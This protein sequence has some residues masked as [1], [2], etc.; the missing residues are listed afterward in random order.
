MQAFSSL[1]ARFFLGGGH[2]LPL[3]PLSIRLEVESD[4]LH[5]EFATREAFWNKFQPGADEHYLLHLMRSDLAFIPELSYIAVEGEQIVGSIAF[6]KSKIVQHNGEDRKELPVITFG[7][8]SVVTTHQSKGIGRK[9]IS[10][11]LRTAK[12]QGHKAVVIYGDPRYYGRLGFRC[13]E[14]YDITN[15]AGEFAISLLV[16]ALTDSPNPLE[17]FGGGCFE[18]ASIFQNFTGEGLE[19]YD[20]A[21]PARENLDMPY[22]TDFAVMRSL[23]YKATTPVL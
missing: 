12:E 19:E 14:R 17:A 5:T 11:G 2:V 18:E 10:H 1:P 21:F 9:L 13:G 4:Y 3:R 23:K 7:P 6:T 16:M 22:H 15:E 20:A 8:V